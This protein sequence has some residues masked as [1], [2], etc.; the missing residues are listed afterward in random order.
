MFILEKHKLE[1]ST[2]FIDCTFN[3]KKLNH[4]IITHQAIIFAFHIHDKFP[5]KRKTVYK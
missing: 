5:N 3:D 2:A 4:D 1:K